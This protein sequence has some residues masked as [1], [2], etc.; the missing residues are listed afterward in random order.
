MMGERTS[1]LPVSTTMPAARLWTKQ[2]RRYRVYDAPD[3]DLPDG[4][5]HQ[6]GVRA[7]RDHEPLRTP[8]GDV[9]LPGA[10]VERNVIDL[11]LSRN[12]HRTTGRSVPKPIPARPAV[13]ATRPD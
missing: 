8:F 10:G 4:P 1:P 6:P 2:T 5:T 12:R 9:G 13:S 11:D 7:G 3:A